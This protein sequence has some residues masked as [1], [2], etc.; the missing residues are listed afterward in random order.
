M[1][2]VLAAFCLGPAASPDVGAAVI[3]GPVSE[4]RTRSFPHRDTLFISAAAVARAWGLY[5][6]ESGEE[7]CRFFS[8]RHSLTLTPGS[9]LAVFDGE[10]LEMDAE[11]VWIDGRLCVPLY[12][13]LV[14]LPGL[15]PPASAERFAAGEK[16]GPRIVLD[17]GHGGRDP[18][19]V[20]EGGSEEKEV[21]LDIARRVRDRLRSSGLEVV[22]SRDSDVYVSLP[23]RVDL[24]NRVEGDIFVSIHAN[25]AENLAA[26]GTETFYA[27]PAG[28]SLSRRL[29]RLENAVLE[30]E[31]FKSFVPPSSTPRGKLLRSRQLAGNVQAR[32]SSAAGSPDRGVKT[33]RFY[34]I[35]RT[36]MPA[37]L[38]ETG[39]LSN[40]R[41]KERLD[42]LSH[43]ERVAEA[44]SE[45]I[46]DYFRYGYGRPAPGA[47]TIDR[48]A[49]AETTE[50][51]EDG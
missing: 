26:S 14:D 28:D 10:D 7:F 29:A 23:D 37:V 13:A 22:M 36:R 47:V 6:F 18:G 5:R 15:V 19:A 34:V 45:G 46:L 25:A 24:A 32:L 12:L 17:P 51:S 8:P 30:L 43:R 20:G 48:A 2:G 31:E 27:A 39:F 42:S 33:A 1:L 16:S 41:E 40:R 44:I 11:A 35:E 50:G 9:A 4:V 21:A 38:V 3:R 49:G